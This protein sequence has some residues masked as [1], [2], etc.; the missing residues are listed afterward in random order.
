MTMSSERIANFLLVPELKLKHFGSDGLILCEK[1]S[2]IE[3]CPKCATA[4]RSVYDH[5]WVQIRD[6]PLRQLRITLKILKR[7]FW[8]KTCSKPF[9]EPVPGVMKGR[10]TTQR[11]RVAVM[12]SCENYSDLKSVREEFKVSFH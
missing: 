6:E 2:Q 5:R 7:R 12:K 4:C 1:E 8:C 3:V 9:T 11:F 10:R